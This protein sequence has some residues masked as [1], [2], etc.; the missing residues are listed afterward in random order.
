MFLSHF[1]GH[2]PRTTQVTPMRPES[3]LG[4]TLSVC[5]S[6][7][8]TFDLHFAGDA[9]NVREEK[10]NLGWCKFSFQCNGSQQRCETLKHKKIISFL[11]VTI[12]NHTHN[13]HIKC[14]LW[15]CVVWVMQWRKGAPRET[16]CMH[17]VTYSVAGQTW[18]VKYGACSTYAVTHKW[19]CKRKN[20]RTQWRIL[21]L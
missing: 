8:K 15:R 3:R 2:I 1:P 20:T 11:E 21:Y 6:N 13:A 12:E 9:R 4:K 14:P 5:N 17:G 7:I 19:L 10:S 16:W 18:H